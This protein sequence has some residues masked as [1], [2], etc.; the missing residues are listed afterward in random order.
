MKTLLLMLA[1]LGVGTVGVAV[2][3]FVRAASTEPSEDIGS[4]G[5][6]RDRNAWPAAP[7]RNNSIT[8][9]LGSYALSA[10]R[11]NLKMYGDEVCILFCVFG[12]GFE[13]HSFPL[14]IQQSSTALG[15]EYERRT[16]RGYS[17]AAE[18]LYTQPR[19][20]ASL[21]D[22]HTGA[23]TTRSDGQMRVGYVF[24]MIKKYLALAEG[25]QIFGSAGG[26]YT[27]AGLSGAINERASGP[28]L[29]LATGFQYRLDRFSVKAEY[30]YVLAP[31]VSL[32]SNDAA[33]STGRIFGD[34]DL[35]GRGLFLGASI[36]F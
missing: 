35:S 31:K 6:S 21:I 15:F 1:T 26:G 12:T 17:L 9:K 30:H 22:P 28:A 7:E 27:Q 20:T 10:R 3:A 34:L 13:V 11:Q 4:S 5:V 16:P 29:Q 36:L 25:L 2:T 19:Y 23:F 33:P 24:V 8:P 18:A 14:E 32:R